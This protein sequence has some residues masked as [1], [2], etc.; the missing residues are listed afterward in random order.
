MT[1][2]QRFSTFLIQTCPDL[3]PVVSRMDTEHSMKP[4]YQEYMAVKGHVQ[5]GKTQFM[6]GL[7]MLSLWCQ[8]SIVIVVRNLHADRDQFL[9]RLQE[10]KSVFSPYL[11]SIRVVKSFTTQ[12]RIKPSIYVALGNGK[13][14]A[15]VVDMLA[16]QPFVL[17][18][19][20]VDALDLGRDTKR[21][22]A[23]GSLKEK[24]TCVF[25]VSATLMDP[26]GKE[27]IKSTN[28]ILLQTHSDYK[29]IL[30][31]T[32]RPL[33][34]KSTF[35]G[36]VTDDLLSKHEPLLPF[37][38]EFSTRLPLVEGE[39]VYPQ[40]GLVNV[41]STVAPYEMLQHRMIKEFPMITTLVYNAKG[42]SL[43]KKG[44]VQPFDGSIAD[45][46]QFLKENGGVEEHPR[47]LI[48]SGQLAGR[49]ISF[50]DLDFEWHLTLL[51]L[52]VSKTCD[53]MELIQKMRLFGRFKDR[54]PLELY[55]T[56]V[57]YSDLIKSYYR[58]EE[59]VLAVATHTTGDQL[60]RDQWKEMT[61]H[62]DKFTKR[63]MT[64]TG[65]CVVQ[66]SDKP[67]VSEWSVGVYEGAEYPPVDA[68]AAYGESLRD[69]PC[70]LGVHL[71]KPPPKMTQTLDELEIKRLRDKMFPSWGKHVGKTKI[72][73]WLDA[74][75]PHRLYSKEDM[76][77]LCDQHQIAMKQVLTAKY[78]SGSNGYGTIL[79]MEN[80]SYRLHTELVSAHLD[81]FGTKDE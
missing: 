8:Q 33:D 32:F 20:E 74:L 35:C 65:M 18:M 45:C 1:D 13:C 47:I 37:L 9:N 38:Q 28:I 63:K 31:V 30:D 12:P 26:L 25:G 17:C 54:L 55:T 79:M 53:E 41:G 40:L 43:V 29:G 51:Y 72:S 50:T 27:N 52:I 76:R 68:F 78:K 59:L 10:M 58:Q 81:Y 67:S 3:A 60:C 4:M 19:D 75:E 70:A 80:G 2:F 56:P 23:M 64:K 21:H 69:E 66:A 7:A 34:G 73:I 61:L 6:M 24:A 5:S 48:F 39:K 16:D 46:L 71:M 11:P 62:E 22:A 44:V 42:I 77:G 15:K 14:L 36:K 57:I 49:G